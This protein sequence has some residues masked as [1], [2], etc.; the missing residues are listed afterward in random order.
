MNEEQS[1]AFQ[2]FSASSFSTPIVRMHAANTCGFNIAMLSTHRHRQFDCCD[3]W[4]R[5]NECK[6][7]R[8]FVRFQNCRRQESR[9][10]TRHSFNE[11]IYAFPFQWFI[12]NRWLSKF[13]AIE[14][15][16]HS[17]NVW[18]ENSIFIALR[19]V[20]FICGC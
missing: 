7:D 20:T 2:T 13:I 10:L 17:N 1:E 16:M 19:L 3:R 6:C 14:L 12:S 9:A 11:N 18:E 4:Y 15:Q 8:V 5:T